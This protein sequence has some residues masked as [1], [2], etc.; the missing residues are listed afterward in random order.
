[1]KPSLD[2]MAIE[3]EMYPTLFPDWDENQLAQD[4]RWNMLQKMFQRFPDD[5][6]FAALGRA[7]DIKRLLGL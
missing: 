3:Y 1:M 4:I 6:V 2:E 5:A 7:L